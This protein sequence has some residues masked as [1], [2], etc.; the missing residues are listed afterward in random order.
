MTKEW[1][2]KEKQQLIEDY[3]ELKHS[4]PSKLSPITL[5]TM[6]SS[7]QLRGKKAKEALVSIERIVSKLKYLM[8]VVYNHTKDKQLLSIK[9]Q[10]EGLMMTLKSAVALLI[11]DKPSR[12]VKLADELVL[13]VE[14]SNE[15]LGQVLGLKAA[16]DRQTVSSMEEARKRMGLDRK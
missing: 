12:A 7:D 10:I 5:Y 2:D 3:S 4:I 1:G 9:L 16:K 14:D 6:L 8:M 11:T 13:V 15:Y